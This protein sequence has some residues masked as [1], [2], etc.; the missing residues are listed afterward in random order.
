MLAKCASTDSLPVWQRGLALEACRVTLSDS[1][2]L[3]TLYSEYDARRN[4]SVVATFVTSVC[5]LLAT[6][7][8]GFAHVIC[9]N[10]DN[11]TE[12]MHE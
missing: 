1:S 3:R 7:A 2:L 5:A 10:P 8:T 6:S 4:S 12:T 9:E 11:R